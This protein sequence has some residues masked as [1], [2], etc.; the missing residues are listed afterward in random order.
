MDWY[1]P[2]HSV[3]AIENGAF[4]SPSTKVGKFTLLIVIFKKH[5]IKLWK[6][7]LDLN[8]WI[9]RGLANMCWYSNVYKLIQCIYPIIPL[10]KGC[11]MRKI[12]NRVQQSWSFTFSHIMVA[13]TCLKKNKSAH[14]YF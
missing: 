5:D 14:L 8:D 3:L 11:K 10:R 6:Y 2:Q 7:I 1:P 13:F 9:S 12:L 4:L